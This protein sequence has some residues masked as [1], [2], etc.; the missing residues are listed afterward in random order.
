[1]GVNS[2]AT[3]PIWFGSVVDSV[4]D[5]GLFCLLVNHLPR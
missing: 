2:F 3:Q 1:V 4:S 5:M